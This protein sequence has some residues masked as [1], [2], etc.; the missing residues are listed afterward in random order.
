MNPISTLNAPSLQ[1]RIDSSKQKLLLYSSLKKI[2]RVALPLLGF[3]L[4]TI[5]GLLN[6]RSL[7][8]SSTLLL[9]AYSPCLEVAVG[10]FE[11]WSYEVQKEVDK[12]TRIQ[13]GL[14]ERKTIYQ[15]WLEA[16]PETPIP[17]VDEQIREVLAN[18]GSD[19]L[20]RNLWEA[21]KI[22]ALH[23]LQNSRKKVER[24]FITHVR[25]HPR[26]TRMLS[27][28]GDY[29]RWQIEHLMNDLPF[30]VFITADGREFTNLD[31]CSRIF[32]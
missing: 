19:E 2:S 6:P 4:L 10:T 17:A 31:D 1:T 24:A 8:I 9:L 21:Q 15:A 29:K 7:P 23:R 28:F 3:L 12:Q 20:R 5:F 32:S 16:I 18:P 26:D 13:Q 11:K 27:D 14:L 30:T 22:R 25:D